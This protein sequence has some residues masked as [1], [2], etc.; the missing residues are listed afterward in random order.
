M[1]KKII[2]IS[3]VGMTEGGI[4][5]VLQDFLIS[6]ESNL[7]DEWD[8]YALVHDKKKFKNSSIKFIEFPHIKKSWIKRIH[9]EL[10][11]S[12]KISQELNADI[13]FSLHDMTSIT[14]AKKRYVY[15]HNPSSFIRPGIRD[16][17]FDPKFFFHSLVYK[18][19]YGLNIKSNT[20]VFVQ[21]TWIKE[22][23][24]KRYKINNI[25]V[26][27]PFKKKEIRKI[28]NINN[29]VIK[30]WIY[31]TFPRHFKNIEIIC[32]AMIILNK[33]R[34]NNINIAITIDGK[35][36]RYSRWIYRKYKDV[37][38]ISF[39]GL[40]SRKELDIKYAMA[41]GLIFPSLL[42][43]WGLPL[44]EAQEYSLPI[45]VS[46]LPYAKESTAFYKKV[47]YFDPKNAENLSKILDDF[48]MNRVDYFSDKNEMF[49]ENTLK[50]DLYGWDELVNYVCEP[51][52]TK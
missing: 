49:H 50:V 3:G 16:L 42:E 40:Q 14:Q 43:T 11:K 44:T 9:F 29:K 51:Y 46:D 33:K 23:F 13:W 26:S 52:D 31:P 21:Q 5:S 36:N 34:L 10:I 19:V 37:K 32:E 17:Y 24:H 1:T 8:I 7:K 38:G 12:K 45:L 30:N 18:Y 4:L 39:I 20:N 35:E 48:N 41:D 2:V 47:K 6:A 27:S 15:A 28:P 22:E 25:L